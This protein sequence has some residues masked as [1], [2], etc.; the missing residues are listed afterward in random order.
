MIVL[1]QLYIIAIY[2]SWLDRCLSYCCDYN[3]ANMENHEC[4]YINASHISE[5]PQLRWWMCVTWSISNLHQ[6]DLMLVC[7]MLLFLLLQILLLLLTILPL[8]LWQP[9]CKLEQKFSQLGNDRVLNIWIH[10]QAWHKPSKLT[11]LLII[12][13]KI[14]YLLKLHSWMDSSGAVNPS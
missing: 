11:R 7:L 12:I 9:Y 3:N 4:L 13:V 8:S 10:C 2:K 14:T 6:R 5:E 1:S